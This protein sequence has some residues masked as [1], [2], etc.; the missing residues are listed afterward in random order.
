MGAAKNIE[1]IESKAPPRPKIIFPLSLQPLERLKTD[2]IKSPMIEIA[3]I[4]TQTQIQLQR[5]TFG[6]YVIPRK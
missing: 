5:E 1:S 3:V 2:S 6:K 4:I